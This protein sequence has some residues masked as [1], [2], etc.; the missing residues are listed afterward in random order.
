[1]A[2]EFAARWRSPTRRV[3]TARL[4]DESAVLAAFAECGADAARPPVGIVVFVGG[5]STDLSQAVT[6]ARDSIWS[7]RS[8]IRAVVAGWH[9]KSPRLWLVTRRGLVVH[10]GE[11]GDPAINALKGLV[12]VLAYEHPDLRATLVDQDGSRDDLESLMGELVSARGDDVVAWRCGRRHAERLSRAALKP[13]E[14]HPVV[15]AGAAYI[16]SGGLGGL[17]LVVARWLVDRGAGRVVLNSRSDPTDEQ[18]TV[19]ADLKE[20]A[21]ISVVSADIAMPGTAERLVAAAEESGLRLRGV[22]HAAAVIDDSL[23][24]AMSKEG[25]E[26]VWA[27][28]AAGALRLHE[29]TVDRALDWW[30]GFSSV[31]SLLGSPG[32]A[33]YA[34]ASAW[35]DGL[36]AWRRASGLPAAA[37]NWGP[38]SEVG[39][40]QSLTA[41]VLDPI[42]PAE[43]IEALETL[44]ATDRTITGVARLRTD[45]ALATF[46]E[47]REMG[48][49]A[50]VIDELNMAG[51]GGDWAGPDALRD[52]E[53]GNVQRVITDQLCARVAAVMGYGD[54]LV[55]KPTQSLTEIGLDSLMAVRIRNAARVDFGVEPPVALLLEGASLRD[56]ATNLVR[57]LGLNGQAADRDTDGVRD[58]ARQRAA[59][60]QEAALR[61]K[62]GERV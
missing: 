17:G 31:A 62:R 24:I 54:H 61:R 16:V 13:P 60:R 7:I 42:T 15:T 32:Q 52:L 46:P 20:R 41:S 22:V 44:L 19:L 55:V 1:M 27:P 36:V 35:L 57:Q 26:R 3:I 25:F 10:A 38:W 39:V 5:H 6:R 2:D 11:S 56:I 12:R 58:R 29:A 18:R 37:I 47:I 43:G 30:V 21:D 23:L 53:P 40:A 14:R 8:T 33:A 51:D 59:A 9:E 4:A 28:K 45:R 49:F 50:T 34:C 48:Y